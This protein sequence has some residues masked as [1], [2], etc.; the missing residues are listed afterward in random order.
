MWN[1]Q[2][3]PLLQKKNQVFLGWKLMICRRKAWHL[4]DLTTRTLFA[5]NDSQGWKRSQKKIFC[6][7]PYL[8]FS[9]KFF[10]ERLLKSHI[11]QM[12]SGRRFKCDACN[13]D[14]PTKSLLRCHQAVHQERRFSCDMCPMTFHTKSVL[15]SHMKSVH[16]EKAR[17][18]RKSKTKMCDHCGVAYPEDTFQVC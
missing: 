18:L 3:W 4:F 6:Q 2:V 7:W 13:K 11:S 1:L 16:D 14:Y 8:I 17:E 12:H 15:K 9:E 10:D 5:T